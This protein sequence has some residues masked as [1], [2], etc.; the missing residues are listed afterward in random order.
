MQKEPQYHDP[1]KGKR[2]PTSHDMGGMVDPALTQRRR[3][4]TVFF[5]V[6]G[7]HI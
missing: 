4:G 2:S 1:Q 3:V 6:Q 5:L 7:A